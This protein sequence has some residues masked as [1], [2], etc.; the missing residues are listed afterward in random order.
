MRAEFERISAAIGEIET[1]L[2]G[3]G[4][5]EKDRQHLQKVLK[6]MKR[7]KVA[8]ERCLATTRS[9]LEKLNAAYSKML[10]KKEAAN[11][12]RLP[13]P[14]P[15]PQGAEPVFFACRHGRIT[16]L[17]GEKLTAALSKGIQAALGGKKATSLSDLEQIGRHF[18]KHALGDEHFRW[19]FYVVNSGGHYIPVGEILWRSPAAGETIAR[20]ADLNSR[21]Q[22]ILAAA[23]GKKRYLQFLVWSDSFDIYLAA[24]READAAG[25]AAGWMVFEV[26]DEFRQNLL[27]SG[28]GDSG[29][30]VD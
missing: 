3:L 17:D 18:E 11:G 15:A 14:R 27:I 10:A 20:I 2:S 12:I 30:R 5:P 9:D 16:R 19:K 1:R 23:A 28:Q 26:N 8:L 29:E 24:R 13:D 25:I 21:Y 22:Q 6:Q 7:Q 4:G